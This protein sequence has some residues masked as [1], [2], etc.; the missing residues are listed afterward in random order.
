MPSSSVA[1]I[2][3][4]ESDDV[5]NDPLM[6]SSP[7]EILEYRCQLESPSSLGRSGLSQIYQLHAREGAA[8]KILQR[9]F[10]KLTDILLNS[11]LV[12]DFQW[13]CA[14][15]FILETIMRRELCRQ[16]GDRIQWK[17]NTRVKYLIVDRASQTVRGVQYRHR[18]SDRSEMV[19]LYGDLI[20]DCSGR[21]SAS[22]KWLKESFDLHVPTIQMHFGCGYLTSIGERFKTDYPEMDAKPM[23]GCTVNPPDRNTGC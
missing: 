23:L 4:I 14:D 16:I 20:I 5:L 22:T 17:S 18:H 19:D 6:K 12:N 8:H 10:P 11:K 13:L 3:I 2:T 1:R 9:L 15:R 7:E 21:N